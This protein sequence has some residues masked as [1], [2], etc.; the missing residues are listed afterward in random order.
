MQ[1]TQKLIESEIE[2]IIFDEKNRTKINK[3][4][5]DMYREKVWGIIIIIK[6]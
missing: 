4:E 2:N 5:K 1:A 3:I 6:K